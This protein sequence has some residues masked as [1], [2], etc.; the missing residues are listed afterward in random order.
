V[1]TAFRVSFGVGVLVGLIVAVGFGVDVGL[2]VDVGS[3]VGTFVGVGSGVGAGHIMQSF[4]C[5]V[6]IGGIIQSARLPSDRQA[7]AVK[8]A[9]LAPFDH[10]E[11]ARLHERGFVAQKVAE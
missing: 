5:L 6:N 2:G 9:K 11:T 3:A 4:G 10:V 7:N 1:T 8:R